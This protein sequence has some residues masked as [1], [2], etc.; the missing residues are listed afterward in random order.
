VQTN[1]LAIV[2][3]R[4]DEVRPSA[5]PVRTH[6]KAA[7]RKLRKLIA[8]FGQVVPI[9][10]D[11]HYAI[12]DG[13]AVHHVLRELGA[14]QIAVV[15]ASG[16]S[17]AELKAL[18]LALN[19]IPHDA[20][21]DNE[22]L[23]AEFSALVTLSFDLEL[24]GFDTVEIDALLD[25]DVPQ[26]N[27]LEAGDDL[28]ARPDNPVTKVGDVWL[29][30]HH[31]VGCGDA[32]DLAARDCQLE[33]HRPAMAFLDPPYNVPV[34]GF[35]S[36]LGGTRHREF[37]QGSGEMSPGQFQHF[38]AGTLNALKSSLAQGA[39]GFVC[40]DWRH[41]FELLSA[42]RASELDLLNLCVWAK[43][44][45][46]MGSLYRSQH[47]L[48]AVFRNGGGPHRNNVEL[49]RHGRHRSN[50]WNYRGLNSFGRD[51]DAL[52]ASHPTVKPVAMIADAIRDVTQRNESVLDLFLGSGST[53]IAAEDTGRRCFG[54]DL[55]PGYVD[56][57]V[58]RWEK[59]T[60]RD[61]V[62]AGTGM[63]FADSAA[64]E[65]HADGGSDVRR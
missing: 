10:V 35:V 32:L 4:L 57:A 24:T 47:E 20:K 38:L 2:H 17:D 21:W 59:H 40:M 51:R 12:I 11:R 54:M 3:L 22:R 49:G 27:V 53:L 25:I 15:V 63:N 41:L 5:E 18:R 6:N 46:G 50:L 9:V 58:Q 30:G 44:N 43:T 34:H 23:R 1:S 45:A 55:D 60:G 13:H 28:P 62:H 64:A 31:R 52:L 19:R 48:V 26:S 36:G 7:L 42:G 61:A 37:V 14:Q 39:V 65:A 8:H 33:G 16:R 29:C 56:V